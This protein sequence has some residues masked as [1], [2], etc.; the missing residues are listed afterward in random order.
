ME[1]ISPCACEASIL[2]R[3]PAA[4]STSIAFG[5]GEFSGLT[6]GTPGASNVDGPPRPAS[7]SVSAVRSGPGRTPPLSL[8]R[9]IAEVDERIAEPAS[10]RVAAPRA[11]TT[12]GAEE[13]VCTAP[14][15]RANR[16]ARSRAHLP[17]NCAPR[18]TSMYCCGL[19]LP[20]SEHDLP[21]GS[22]NAQRS[23][24]RD[25]APFTAGVLGRGNERLLLAASHDHQ[26]SHAHH[27]QYAS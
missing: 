27:E 18:W 21:M 24:A 9:R 2:G 13:T 5:C 11:R 17:H 12:N 7:N 1:A 26:P 22:I 4:R 20:R 15:G 14:L 10:L 8:T 16:R 23:H 6:K 19:A 25:A 3:C